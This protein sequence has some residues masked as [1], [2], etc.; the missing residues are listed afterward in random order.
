M[1]FSD[2]VNTNVSN[3][4]LVSKL[5]PTTDLEKEVEMLLTAGGSSEA[6]VAEKEMEELKSKVRDH[7]RVML[8]PCRDPLALAH[9]CMRACP[10]TT[11]WQYVIPVATEA[12]L[13]RGTYFSLVGH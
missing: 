12:K 6:A 10:H 2:K 4:A 1:F 7:D 13:Y 3:A 9:S 11:H 5:Q 8:L